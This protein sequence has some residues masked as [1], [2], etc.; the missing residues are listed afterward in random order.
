VCA[1]RCGGFPALGAGQGCED[2][3]HSTPSFLVLFESSWSCSHF[4]FGQTWTVSQRGSP[5]QSALRAPGVGRGTL[6]G[7]SSCSLGS[8][9][10]TLG[11]WERGFKEAWSTGPRESPLRRASVLPASTRAGSLQGSGPPTSCG[12]ESNSRSFQQRQVSSRERP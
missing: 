9:F 4:W 2:I 10:R 6:P 3:P 8:G 12:H 11:L 7:A 1:R 5:G